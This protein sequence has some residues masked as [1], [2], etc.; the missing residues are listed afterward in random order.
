MAEEEIDLQ[1]KF[2]DLQPIRSAPSLFTVNGCG[3]MLYGSR[4]LDHDTQTFVKT[5]CLT[6]IFVPIMA[7]RA[8]RVA[9]AERGWYFIGREPLSAFARIWNVLF[10]FGVLA[11]IGIG[12]W[13]AHTSSPEYVAKK[14]LEAANELAEAGQWREAADKYVKVIRS[15]TS[16]TA[17][18]RTQIDKL[19]ADTAEKVDAAEGLALIALGDQL[20]RQ[21]INIA[22]LEE[23]ALSLASRHAAR[24]PRKALEILHIVDKFPIVPEERTAEVTK[25]RTKVR[26]TVLVA[27]VAAEKDAVDAASELAVI[28]ESQGKLDECKKLLEPHLARLGDME[29]A[30]ILGQIYARGGEIE[31]AHKLLVPYCKTR[32][33]SLHDAEKQFEDAYV[34]AQ[35][36][37]ILQLRSGQAPASFERKYNA[38]SKE[39]RAALVQEYI[40][41]KVREDVG[42]ADARRALQ[43][44]GRVVPVALDLGIVLLRRSRTLKDPAARQKELKQAEETFL[45]VR[46]MAGETEQYQIYLGQ[47]YYWMGQEKKGRPLF[48]KF[49]ARRKR[50]YRGLM[51]L[52]STL[53]SLGAMAEARKL[54]EEAHKKAAKPDEKHAAASL[55]TLLAKDVDDKIVW[56]RRCDSTSLSV[57]AD[58][59]STQGLQ[60]ERN[61]RNADAAGFYRNAI[62][63]YEKMPVNTATLNNGGLA[64][65]SLYRVTADKTAFNNGLK[66]IEKAVALSPSDS[67]VLHNSAST[68]YK[69]AAADIIGKSLNLPALQMSADLKLLRYLYRDEKE[70]AAWRRRVATHPIMKRAN[71]YYEKVMLLAPKNSEAYL[72][73]AATRSFINDVDGLKALLEKLRTANVETD[74]LDRF[75]REY[76]QGKNLDKVRRSQRVSADRMRKAIQKMKVRKDATF[77]LACAEFSG[78]LIALGTLGDR[79]D[80]DEIVRL[81]DDGHN[82]AP[83]SATRHSLISAL[84]FRALNSLAAKSPA[85]A[86]AVKKHR[87]TMGPR[88]LLAAL[89]RHHETAR[90][91]L[92]NDPDV[93]RLIALEQES[94]KAFPKGR[95]AVEWAL[96]SRIDPD[97]A[98]RVARAI[99][100]NAADELYWK[101]MEHI[102]RINPSRAMDSYWKLE[103][104]GKPAEAAKI[105]EEF[106]K[107]GIE[108]PVPK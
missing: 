108:L 61:D 84:A 17:A 66:R 99:H 44:A 43:N 11:A 14:D 48:D 40:A 91:H 35:N 62:A 77:A 105:V 29:G 60:A 16:S 34:K 36:V 83:S 46:G 82:A 106:R 55:R 75:T 81:A 54:V 15:N 56:L 89:A 2:P 87:R 64:W 88:Y 33:K 72:Q 41:N 9:N 70:R 80:P 47:V 31:K 93:K 67:I 38:A 51:M 59:N 21:A 63:I 79:V 19:F 42:V 12:S 73:M 104:D 58:L 100:D 1:E 26:E 30:R 24:S 23:L 22:N 18:A 95:D 65:L 49:L 69:A 98:G 32:L 6:F 5:H 53:R 37:V 90:A 27:L 92:K 28:R 25:R 57:Q 50:D 76:I 71:E 96:L 10:V 85:L 39:R 107:L 7:L 4:D 97:E 13:A 52:S 101:I 20:R 3:L 8:Y 103:I 68:L 78:D 94:A 102:A 45:A 86:G 74:A